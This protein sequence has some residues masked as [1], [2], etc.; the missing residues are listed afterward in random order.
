MRSKFSPRKIPFPAFS[1]EHF[2]K[3]MN[4]TKMQQLYQLFIVP[5]SIVIDKTDAIKKV[6][7]KGRDVQ[8]PLDE[9]TLL[10]RHQYISI[11]RKIYQS[12]RFNNVFRKMP[13]GNNLFFQISGV[14]T[15]VCTY[16]Y[17]MLCAFFLLLMHNLRKLLSEPYSNLKPRISDFKA[18]NIPQNLRTKLYYYLKQQAALLQGLQ[19]DY[20]AFRI[21]CGLAFVI[22]PK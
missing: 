6:T 11:M 14:R 4:T 18:F 17:A 5:I 10:Q 9:Q 2:K 19:G 12:S 22:K 21:F 15:G 16:I 3:I 7:S 8:Y 1:A 13:S 20:I